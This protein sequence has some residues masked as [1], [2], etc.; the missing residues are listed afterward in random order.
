MFTSTFKAQ[1]RIYIADL[2]Q[3]GHVRWIN[4]MNKEPINYRKGEC[5][6][7][8]FKD[9]IAVV[10]YSS[11]FEPSR[12]YAVTFEDAESSNNLDDIKVSYVLLSA[13]DLDEDLFEEI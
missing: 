1:N 12:V 5:S 10:K 9:N 8:K 13:L 11:C 6:L 7:L 3:P 2:E 4:F